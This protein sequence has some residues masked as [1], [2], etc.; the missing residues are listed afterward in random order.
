MVRCRGVVSGP[1][2]GRGPGEFDLG[3]ACLSVQR[4]HAVVEAALDRDHLAEQALGLVELTEADPGDGDGPAQLVQIAEGAHVAQ[5]LAR[6]RRPVEN[7]LPVAG[8]RC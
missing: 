3:E 8:S 4:E 6:D 7:A 2:G 5:A 1:R